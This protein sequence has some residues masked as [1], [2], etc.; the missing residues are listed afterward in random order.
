MNKSEY[1][2]SEDNSLFVSKGSRDL[3]EKAVKK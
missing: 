3:Y 2:V 1:Y